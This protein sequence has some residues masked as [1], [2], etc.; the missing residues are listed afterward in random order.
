MESDN[1]KTIEANMKRLVLTAVFLVFFTAV[2]VLAALWWFLD[3]L[4]IIN[5]GAGMGIAAVFSFIWYFSLS[6][7]ATALAESAIKDASALATAASAMAVGN[8]GTS[9]RGGTEDEFGQIE[10]AL[11]QLSMVQ[12]GLIKDVNTLVKHHAQGNTDALIDEKPYAGDY[13]ALVTGI[14]SMVSDYANS[15]FA[16]AEVAKSFSDGELKVR[17]SPLS[18]KKSEV[19]KAIE[20]LRQSIET[21]SREKQTAQAS[22]NSAKDEAENLNRQLVAAREDAAYAR[23]DASEARHAASAAE[24][25]ASTAKREADRAKE[26]ARKAAER[27]KTATAPI[28]QRP[29]TQAMPKPEPAPSVPQNKP[30]YPKLTSHTSAPAPAIKSVKVVAP[31][32]AYEYDSKDLGKF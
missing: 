28:V 32:G 12:A 21:M 29:V 25:E 3:D 24:R 2:V 9:L 15:L 19:N 8:F 1:R 23:R 10:V 22:A 30:T 27:L 17:F 20:N 4:S 14:N 11:A 16:I 6:A 13:R 31:S 5:V 26:E 7:A 18:G